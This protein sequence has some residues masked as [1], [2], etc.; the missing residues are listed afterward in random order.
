MLEHHAIW[1]LVSALA[2]PTS[3]R[4]LEVE[5]AILTNDHRP[6]MA[7][8]RLLWVPL[9]RRTLSSIALTGTEAIRAAAISY[10]SI[11]CAA[12]KTTKQ[13]QTKKKKKASNTFKQYD[14]K[15]A[16]QFPLLDAMR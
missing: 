15:N 9:E 10:Q 1:M 12:T 6:P 3:D 5:N 2:F 8:P 11:R 14:L 4:N 7:H 13:Q 16:E